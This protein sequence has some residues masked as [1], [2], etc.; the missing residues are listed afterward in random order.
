[1]KN[2]ARMCISV[3]LVVIS[4]ICV[5]NVQATLDT[6]MYGFG[7][8]TNN[9]ATNAAIGQYQLLVEVSDKGTVMQG[10]EQFGLVGFKFSNN[11]PADCVITEIYF[12]DGSILGF[13][14][15]DESL[16]GVD[17][18]EDEVG[19][20]SPKNLPGGKAIAPEFIA[21]TAFS[22][23]PLN[24]EPE[25]G[26]GPGEWVE[27]VYSLQSGKTYANIIE[28]LNDGDLRIGTHVQSYAD[29]GSESFVNV[30]EP[31]TMVLLG[32]GG[33]LLRKRRKV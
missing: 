23:E 12:Q 8:I 33:F 11:G 27:I 31:T 20:V 26:V 14:S 2:Q 10:G 6:K 19:S 15:I 1:M 25:W 16:S 9:S 18:K 29:G 3:V 17:F 5:A 24:P 21:T 13:A 7:C 28:E 30:P 4:M 22:I 32:L